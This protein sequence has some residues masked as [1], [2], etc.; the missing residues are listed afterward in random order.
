MSTEW[1]VSIWRKGQKA[2][3][4]EENHPCLR[5]HS[6]H[7]P[8]RLLLPCSYPGTFVPHWLQQEGP[9]THSWGSTMSLTSGAICHMGLSDLFLSTAAGIALYFTKCR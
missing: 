9:P 5:P 8:L 7:G 1:R 4:S 2:P 6:C 3:T